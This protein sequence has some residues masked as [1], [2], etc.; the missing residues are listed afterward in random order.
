MNKKILIID[1]HFDKGLLELL[2]T[3]YQV[4]LISSV[5]DFE[6]IVFEAFLDFSSFDVIFIDPQM[7]PE[8]LF[9]VDESLNGQKTGCLL[10]DK[11]LREIECPI[12]IWAQES[13]IVDLCEESFSAKNLEFRRKAKTMKSI[14]DLIDLL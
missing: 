10:Y 1:E 4:E 11:Y 13:Y 5:S 8:S 9:S 2:G 6:T 3:S 7:E 12:I 14:V